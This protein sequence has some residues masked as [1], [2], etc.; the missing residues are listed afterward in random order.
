RDWRRSMALSLLRRMSG[1]QR[2]LLLVL[3][4]N[5]TLLLLGLFIA[6]SSFTSPEGWEALLGAVGMQAALALLAL[7]G[8]LS[9]A[10]Y[11]R[12]MGICLGLGALFA[13]VYL[14]LLTRDFAGV[15]WGPDDDP[16]LLYSLFVGI[17]LVAGVAASLRAQQ[18]RD[19]IVAGVWAL[20]IGTA[21]WSL[22][23]LLLNYT[24]WGS[25]HWYHFWLQDGAIDDFHQSG[26]HDLNAFLL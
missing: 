19:G 1:A 12:T 24:L 3:A 10:K 22:G 2:L 15:S 11:P 5:M 13:A 26:S 16:T 8:P 14:G 25:A 4:A 7:I 17:A 23:T 9:F 21:L 20:L 18:L 6:P